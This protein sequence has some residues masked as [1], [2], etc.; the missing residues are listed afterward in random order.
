MKIND[1]VSLHIE[2]YMMQVLFAPPFS[3]CFTG[4]VLHKGYVKGWVYRQMRNRAYNKKGLIYIYHLQI[5]RIS[6]ASI[7]MS[8]FYSVSLLA[9]V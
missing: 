4:W 5:Y 9:P 7:H 2:V 1:A 6:M 3:H 8:H